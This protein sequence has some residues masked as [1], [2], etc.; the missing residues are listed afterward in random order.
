MVTVDPIVYS[1]RG[2]SGIP[3]A[4]MSL[5]EFERGIVLGGNR[6]KG[7]RGEGLCPSAGKKRIR[8]GSAGARADKKLTHDAP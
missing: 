3:V 4:K 1:G 5:P 7:V 2:K 6:G 8:H